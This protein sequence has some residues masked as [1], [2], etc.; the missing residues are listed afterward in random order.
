[1]KKAKKLSFVGMVRKTD[2]S[3]KRGS[4]YG[5]LKIPSNVDVFTPEANTNV[6]MDFIPYLVS[7][8][9]HPDRNENNDP[10]I[11]VEGSYWWERPFK[12]HRN[13]GADKKTY[14]CPTSIGKKCP[15]CEYREKLR[16]EEG[17]EETI[18]Q[19]KTTDKNLYAVFIKGNKKIDPNQLFLFEFSDFLF[20]KRFEEQ[21]AE[22]DPEKFE[23]FP[24]PQ[25]GYSIVVRFAEN[26]FA[27]NKFADPTRFDF[28]DR[29]E[30][31]DDEVLDT[32]PALD[33]CLTILGYD[34]LKDKFYSSFTA[35]DD[36][37]D[38]DEDEDLK[39]G[40]TKIKA[41]KATKPEP[42]DEDEDDEDEDEEE[43]PEDEDEEEEPEPVKQKQPSRNRKTKELKCP[44]NYVFGKDN[45]KYDDCEDCDLWNECYAKK[46]ELKKHGANTKK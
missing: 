40:K 41:R 20:Q 2:E 12:I 5:Y 18:K 29:K 27:G 23:V 4:N 43:E 11:A 39:R 8:K 10:P 32:I 46:Q 33:E 28:A 21:L 17:D 9:N 38:D 19:L 14:V 31:Y 13:I 26:S 22:N 45:D 1:M 36:E 34:E 35:E 44:E 37:E 30:Q 3:H 7:V 24:D 15:I 6:V 16:K 42:E 25:L